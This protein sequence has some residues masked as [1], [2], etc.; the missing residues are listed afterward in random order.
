MLLSLSVIAVYTL[1]TMIVVPFGRFM[2]IRKDL[3]E[4]T[5]LEVEGCTR[6]GDKFWKW[7]EEQV[8]RYL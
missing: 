1:L 4:A 7:T 8:E 6:V 2:E 5:K 3:R